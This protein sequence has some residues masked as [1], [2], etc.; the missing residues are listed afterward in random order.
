M[1]R[2]PSG[3]LERL[4]REISLVELAREAGLALERRGEDLVARCCF[5]D[6]DDTPSLSIHPEKNVFHCFG[7]GAKGN[8]VDWVM[9]A[10]RVSFRHAVEILRRRAG[11]PPPNGER[12]EE[13][14]PS[15]APPR[16]AKP[17]APLDRSAEDQELLAQVVEHY[18]GTLKES[19]EALRYLEQRG[20]VHPELIDR[21]RLGFA[22]RTLGY[23]LPLKATKAGEELRGR[24]QRL[25][26]LRASG[27]EHFN[28]RVICPIFDAEG[29]VVELY[30]RTITPNLR[31]GTPDHLYL[32]GP[33][34]GVFH[35]AALRASKEI[36]LCEALFDALTFW[37][38]G[39]RNVTSAYGVN[40]FTDEHLE[41]FEAYRIERVLIAYDR[42]EVGE[43]A[44]EELAKKLEPKGI[45]CYRV[46]FPRGMDANE[47]AR[48]VQP[49]EKSLDLVL[50]H[51]APMG[52]AAER[53]Y[54]VETTPLELSEPP[55]EASP[56][57]LARCLSS[58]SES[59][60]QRAEEERQ[61]TEADSPDAPPALAP[62]GDSAP[63]S[64][65]SLLPVA[66]ALSI[67]CE[68][69]SE[70]VVVT[71]GDRRYRVRGFSKN[72][73]Y[74]SLRVNLLASRGDAFHVD[75]LDL[76]ASRQRV[77]FEKQAALELGVK[78]DV[79]HRDVGRVF[80][81]L[82][83]LQ[84]EAIRKALEPKATHP[85]LSAEEQQRA[86]ELLKDP[87]LLDRIAL[88]LERCGLV[89]ETTNKLVTYLAA[90]SRKQDRP[91]AV[92]IQ[93]SSAAGKSALMNAVLALVPE[94]ERVH[95]SA[96][97]GQSLFYM[98]ERDLKHKVLAIA[99]EEGAERASYA[100]K[101]LQ[102]EGELT[103]ASTGKDPQ[104]GRL[105]TH[106][107][108]VEGP[109]AILL[110]TT[111]VEIDDELLN[112]CLI[113]TVDEDR[114]QTR[115]IHRLQR[116]RHTLEG[117]LEL[118]ER[119]AILKLHQNAQRL[120]RPL[121]VINPYAEEL[122]FPDSAARMRRDHEKYLGLIATV[123]LLHQH[124]REVKAATQSGQPV[125]YV[126]ATLLDIATANRL[127]RE[128]LGRTLDELPPQTRK[129]LVL[130]DRHVRAECAR[131]QMAR[132]D[133]RFS[134]REVRA[135]TGWG[136][137]Q[138]R[139]HLFRL[140]S[141][142]Y[143]VAHRGSRGQSYVYELAYEVQE[144]EETACLA[145]LIDVER[146]GYDG[147]NAGFGSH[148]AGFEPENAGSSRGLLGGIAGGARGRSER[149]LVRLSGDFGP[150]SSESAHLESELE[151]SSYVLES[152]RTRSNGTPIAD[153]LTSSFDLLSLARQA[154]RE[155]ASP[156]LEP[157]H[158][159]DRG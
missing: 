38:A 69:K 117:Q 125:E 74:D 43:R 150:E 93:S 5:H 138:L 53:C 54:H 17:L 22:N 100:L 1:A 85:A 113:L 127:A 27:H 108:R 39:F 142:E 46:Q 97:T 83:E 64:A 148:F 7:C 106:E 147:K 49:A 19:P 99:E 2:I 158:T 159:P 12:A 124:Q 88:D 37:C 92:L 28:G 145:G 109:V 56:F 95:Y 42:D 154:A 87:Q 29:R 105:V 151:N 137:T 52:E 60:K 121:A 133:Y 91:L 111:A 61:E 102:S 20:L 63:A 68:V 114:E 18:H 36:I 140:E 4:R 79:V 58:E 116:K 73:S 107:Y 135:V 62:I 149:A 31:S 155:I 25:G 96:M 34:R 141:L 33:R 110:T 80:L 81:K 134:R 132:S 89:G 115:A 10:E 50:R 78:E 143:L 26:I 76:Y 112:R 139:L 144:G 59:E 118:R 128:V 44:A 40:G 84:D 131:L 41:A 15:G 94:E 103:I 157:A 48:K 6:G 98:S 90:V 32:P 82:E 136:D 24:L 23:R 77:A 66:P 104:S 86:L 75:T 126:E 71:L 9:R 3:E 57:S 45:A 156:E 130:L 65:A 123:A 55:I 16:R 119:P 11:S 129:L 30:G 122:T 35:L 152:R 153:L 47:Y 70:E 101:L 13:K 67:P 51:A 14:K 21:F 72:L 8:V 120:L 146:L